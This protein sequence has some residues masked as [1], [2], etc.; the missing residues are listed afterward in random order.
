MPAGATALPPVTPGR[1]G[2]RNG[3]TGGPMEPPLDRG[4]EHPFD[5]PFSIMQ[6]MQAELF[7]LR[8]ELCIERQERK[9]EVAAIRSEIQDLKDLIRRDELKQQ[10]DHDRLAK[11]LQDLTNKEE[12]DWTSTRRDMEAEFAKRC[13]VTDFQTL[14]ARVDDD[15]ADLANVGGALRKTLSDLEARIEA[16]SA[17]DNEFAQAMQR[18]LQDQ[19]SRLDQNALNDQIFEDTVVAQLRMAGQLLQA[20]GALDR[21]PVDP[22]AWTAASL[23]HE[24]AARGLKP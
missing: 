2:S 22:A 18:E 19:R 3:L 21:K 12:N 10:A 14:S 24:E 5:T 17:G 23:A 20:A 8:E 11:G 13:R 16:N 7:K 9:A 1:P 15:I 4:S 6:T